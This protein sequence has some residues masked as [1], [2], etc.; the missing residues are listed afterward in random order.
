MRHSEKFRDLRTSL[1]SLAT[2]VVGSF[3]FQTDILKDTCRLRI[4]GSGLRG[5]KSQS[6]C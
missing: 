6:Y 4:L 5:A 1:K 3:S 2:T